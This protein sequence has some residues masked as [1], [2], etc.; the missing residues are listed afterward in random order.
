[1]ENFIIKRHSRKRQQCHLI[2]GLQQFKNHLYLNFLWL[3]FVAGIAFLIV[4]VK[5]LDIDVNPILNAAVY[6]CIKILIIVIPI[7]CAIRIIQFV[8]SCFALKDEADLKIVFSNKNNIKKQPPILIFKK[9]DRKTGIIKREF[10]STISLS[11][12]QEKRE[13]ICDRMN[14][15]IIGDFSYGGKYKDKGYRIYF[16]AV[17]GRKP[18]ERGILYD[19]I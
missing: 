15:R 1:M 16:E 13:A 7:M 6:I 14:I 2:V 12:W 17:K 18:K 4:S 9:K 3:I 19:E 5:D 8:G 10:Y 11:V